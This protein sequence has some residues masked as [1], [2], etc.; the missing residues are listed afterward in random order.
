[1]LDW[2]CLSAFLVMTVTPG[3]PGARE[4][5]QIMR[6]EEQ[7]VSDARIQLSRRFSLDFT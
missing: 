1:M 7:Y 4:A 6:K 2:W 5:I 3:G